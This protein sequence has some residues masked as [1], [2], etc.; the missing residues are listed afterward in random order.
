MQLRAQI[1]HAESTLPTPIDAAYTVMS[2]GAPLYK[3]FAFVYKH[4]KGTRH[5]FWDLTLYLKPKSL[6]EAVSLLASTGGHILAGG[7]DFYP[8][9]GERLPQGDVVD[10]TSIAEIRG[11]SWQPDHIRFGGLT[12]WTEVIRSPLP[13]C[14]DALKEAA[15]EV[16][17]IQIQNRG[18][19]AGNLCNASPAA[20]GVPPFL[21]LDAEVELLSKAGQR[22]IPLSQFLI[23]NRRTSRAADE[24][25]TAVCIPRRMENA[26]SAFL[27]LGA[28]RYLVISIS[29]V[30]AV[31][32]KDASGCVA[33]A[34]VAVGSC[35][36]TARRLIQLEKDLVGLR[37]NAE[38]ADTIRP[39]HLS[40]L[41]PIDDIRATAEY[42]LDASL[43][44]V[45]RALEICMGRAA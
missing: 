21:A 5:G 12:S 44:L 39:E 40:P 13:P 17:S 22:R 14:F 10:I 34:H 26:G 7:T 32:Q 11:I 45:R 23:G 43:T 15:R 27:K 9:L 42:R 24:I 41:S 38:I 33:E 8:A 4:S 31:L 1:I 30:A 19:V 25:L 37:A 6:N 18:T 20:D 2:L 16:G 28:R 3:H 29:M 36:A 35:S